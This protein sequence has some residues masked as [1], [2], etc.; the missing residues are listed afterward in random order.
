MK[1]I[2]VTSAEQPMQQFLTLAAHEPLVMRLPNGQVF[3]LTAVEE[4]RE[5]HD[6][7]FGD[8]VARTRQ[9]AAIMALL[10]ERSRETTR[11]SAAEARKRLGLT[12]G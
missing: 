11:V 1:T 2:E 8:E 12:D 7:E 6:E 5:T 3:L 4:A 9:N 10:H